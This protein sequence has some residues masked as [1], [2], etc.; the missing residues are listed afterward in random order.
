MIKPPYTKWI[1]D[2][3]TKLGF[4]R[5]MTASGEDVV[6]AV[7]K[8]ADQITD[9]K[10]F[11][12]TARN[13][14]ISVAQNVATKISSNQVHCLSRGNLATI[15]GEFILAEQI[16]SGSKAD[17]FTGFP[18][19]LSS[20]G[21]TWIGIYELDTGKIYRLLLESTALKTYYSGNITP[22]D[23][24]FMPYIYFMDTTL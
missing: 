11:T 20:N 1:N 14:A 9:I 21:N 12:N 13:H 2:I 16:N 10:D 3:K 6:D 7:N 4:T 17:L 23:Y 8:Q 19:K 15:Y 5:T 24:I 18:L 22:G